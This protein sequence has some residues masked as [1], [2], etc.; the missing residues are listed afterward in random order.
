[1]G[2]VIQNIVM[3][4]SGNVATHLA[5]VFYWKGKKISQVYS[6]DPEHAKQLAN[7]VG[8]EAIDDLFSLT[9]D[10]DLYIIAVPDKSIEEVAGKLLLKDKLLVHTSGSV[11][12]EALSGASL[13]YG[14]FYPLNTFSKEKG[15]DFSNTP[16]CIEG[17]TTSNKEKLVR[18]GK[19][20]SGDVRIITSEERQI[21]HMAAVF[22]SNFTNHMYGIA[23]DILES[24][25]LPFDILK[26]LIMETAQ[27]IWKHKPADAQTGPAVREDIS[28]ID[29]HMEIL[30]KFPE[31]KKI[32]EMMTKD[33]V[34]RRKTRLRQGYGGQ[35]ND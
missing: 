10:A 32:Y 25:E 11:A 23:E 4:G 34:R 30:G 18:L 5:E 3:I 1:M 6:R 35:S 8:S 28:T 33:I 19:V 24:H 13:N 17:N 21:I 9:T 27:K 14:I 26:P 20:I 2:A 15:I 29:T 31:F 7:K 16:I 22:V 12:M